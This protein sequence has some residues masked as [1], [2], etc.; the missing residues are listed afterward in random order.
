MTMETNETFGHDKK[1]QDD[2]KESAH[3]IWLAGLGALAAAEQEGSKVFNRLVDRGR[4]V[5]SRGKVDFKDQVDQAKVKVDQA[6][7][8]VEDTVENWTAKLDETVTSTLHRLGVPTREEIRNLTRRV[9][10]LNA[11]IETLRP[12]VT[13]AETVIVTPAAVA[14]EPTDPSKIVV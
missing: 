8:K 7:A 12:R 6:K 3:R 9:E 1:L 2:L 11:K 13:P 14:A 5:E 4:D 10:E